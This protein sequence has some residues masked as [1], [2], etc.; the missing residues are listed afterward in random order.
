MQ[1][2]KESLSM[3]DNCSMMQEIFGPILEKKNVSVESNWE[4][5]F[6]IFT[7]K[8]AMQK[9]IQAIFENIF[10]HTKA[11]SSIVVNAKPNVIKIKN[12]IDT[13]GESALFSSYIGLKMIERLSSK[14]SYEYST[15]SDETYFYTTLT[16]HN[17][18][19]DNCSI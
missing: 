12:E 9:V 10:I 17:L 8:E 7:Y 18:A 4:N 16:L 3:E 11:G 1:L 15:C 13:T 19:E 2:K 6:V 5:N 14:L